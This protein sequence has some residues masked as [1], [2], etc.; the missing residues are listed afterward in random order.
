LRKATEQSL[1]GS[2][3]PDSKEGREEDTQPTKSQS[4]RISWNPG[5]CV[6]IPI[7][8]VRKMEAGD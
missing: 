5:L 8:Q 3:K 4:I 7:F 1:G 6:S 2:R